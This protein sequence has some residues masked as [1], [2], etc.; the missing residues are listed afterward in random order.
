VDQAFVE[1]EG[2][3]ARVKT[4]SPP[5]AGYFDSVA[6]FGFLGGGAGLTVA[7]VSFN[8]CFRCGRSTAAARQALPG[9]ITGKVLQTSGHRTPSSPRTPAS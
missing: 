6:A 3:N 9:V 8:H 5:F 2:P 1:G 4:A 7:A